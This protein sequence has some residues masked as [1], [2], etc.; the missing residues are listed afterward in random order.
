[1]DGHSDKLNAKIR[2]AEVEKVPHMFILGPKEVETET[3]SVRSRIDSNFTGTLKLS[4]A[5]EYLKKVIA[6]RELPNC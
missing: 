1:V 3:V 2:R 4:S 5:I 6:S